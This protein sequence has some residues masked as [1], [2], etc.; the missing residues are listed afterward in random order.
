MLEAQKKM[1]AEKAQLAKELKN[2][3]HRRNRLKHKAR[4]LSASDLAS[5]LVMRQEEED[6]KLK[7]AAKRRWNPQSAPG[8]GEMVDIGDRPPNGEDRAE[9]SESNGGDEQE[10][11][12]AADPPALT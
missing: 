9:E 3:Q 8:A 5:V 4:L 1:R 11:R 2:A 12:D 10:A 7:A 6:Q